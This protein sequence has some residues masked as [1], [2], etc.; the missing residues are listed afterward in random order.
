MTDETLDTQA[1]EPEDTRDVVERELDKLEVAESAE[2]AQE[3][4]PR[5]DGRGS[6]G[7]FAKSGAVE[8]DAPIEPQ[9]QEAEQ[10]NESPA[11]NPFSAWRKDAQTALSALPPETQQYIIDRE[12]QFHRG[13]EQYKTEAH[14]GRSIGASLAPYMDYL[15]QLQVTP[16]QAIPRLI[17]TE[18]VLRTAGPQERTEMF[19]KL[20]HDYG[21]DVQ[22]LTNVQ[23]DPYRYSMEQRLAE[24]QAQLEQLSQS[25]QMAD[26]A[27]LSQSI[28]QFAST[29]EHFDE[30]RET[31]AD[32]LDRGFAG[33][34]DDAYDKAVR[35]ND[36]LFTRQQ[37]GAQMGN[38]QRADLAAKAAKSAAVSVKGAPTGVTRPPEPK[39][40]EDAVRQAMAQIGI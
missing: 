15:G 10:V 5:D 37:H 22:G 9:Q 8:A 39:T 14:R 36:G 7:R 28:G 34:L 29:H 17:E 12:Q 13:I 30:V 21:I 31:M 40:T 2:P 16:E 19:L 26:D 18:R 20:A 11:R 25:R 4:A 1:A 23:F 32:L 33:N 6:D 35:L 27:Q 38:M 24:Q 3:A